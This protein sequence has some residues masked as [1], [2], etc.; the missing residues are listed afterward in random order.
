MAI[1]TAEL[2]V[3]L[4]TGTSSGSGNTTGSTP[5]ASLGGQMSTTQLVDASLNNLFDDLTG[6]E[7]AAAGAEV[8][9][10]TIFFHNSNGS[11]TLQNPKVYLVGGD[12]AGGA[13]MAIALDNV[14]VVAA[15]SASPQ[16]AVAAN[17][18]TAPTPVGAFSAPSTY[19]GGLTPSANIGPGQCFAVVV[20]RTAANSAAVN[21][22]TLTIRLEGDTLP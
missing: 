6:A 18:S 10:R 7:N 13:T 21:P 11:L 3:K 9:Y 14:G 8:E 22:D 5:A 12:P 17:E 4:S 20:R 1:S 19:A 2:L 15:G 16:S